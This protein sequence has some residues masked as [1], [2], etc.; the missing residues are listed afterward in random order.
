MPGGHDCA[1]AL[2]FAHVSPGGQMTHRPVGGDESQ[3][4]PTGQSEEA[5]TPGSE[6]EAQARSRRL[7]KEGARTSPRRPLND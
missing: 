1:G 4:W 7:R 6:H 3:Y 2:G 5:E